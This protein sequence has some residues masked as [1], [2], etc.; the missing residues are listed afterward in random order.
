MHVATDRWVDPHASLPSKGRENW[1]MEFFPSSSS[2]G[3]FFAPLFSRSMTDT[4]IWER[5][6]RHQKKK[7]F[8]FP[9]VWSFLFPLGIWEAFNWFFSLPS[10]RLS[11]LPS[12][13]RLRPK[14]MKYGIFG[15][16][17]GVWLWWIKLVAP[18][19]L[20]QTL[21]PRPFLSVFSKLCLAAR[22]D[23]NT[24]Y[25]HTI[26]SQPDNLNLP[27]LSKQLCL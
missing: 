11:P 8:V 15:G 16:E 12:L 7:S 26:F 3:H 27:K 25:F 5:K 14:E 9:F 2:C 19:T 1:G 24:V 13:L 22:G 20:A 23:F 4:Q 17:K 21:N 10:A 6:K 18:Q